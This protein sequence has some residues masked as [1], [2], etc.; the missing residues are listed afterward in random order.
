MV[1]AC[2]TDQVFVTKKKLPTSGVLPPKASAI[3]KFCRTHDFFIEENHETGELCLK[4][5]EKVGGTGDE[6][7]T[8]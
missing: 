6:S 5:A 1:Y 2:R 7:E 3:R 8:V 4:A